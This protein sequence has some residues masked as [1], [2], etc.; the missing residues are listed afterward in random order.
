VSEYENILLI[1][2]EFEMTAHLS[3]LKQLIH[4]YKTCKINTLWIHVIWQVQHIDK[5]EVRLR[6]H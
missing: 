4:D 6:I 1:V 2:T 3:Y 5:H